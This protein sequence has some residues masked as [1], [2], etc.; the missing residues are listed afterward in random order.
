MVGL[1]EIPENEY[2]Y[3]IELIDIGFPKVKD[4]Y[5]KRLKGIQRK[6]L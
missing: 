5:K 3:H 1:R 6:M 4:M 2:T